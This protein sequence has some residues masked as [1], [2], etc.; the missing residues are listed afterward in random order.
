MTRLGF[1]G[2]Q[3]FPA[4]A[5]SSV[6]DDHGSN[7]EHVA[8]ALDSILRNAPLASAARAASVRI[9]A[10]PDGAGRAAELVETL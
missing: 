9:A 10:A 6:M 8:V 4:R 1:A 5:E 7:R 3:R 2:A